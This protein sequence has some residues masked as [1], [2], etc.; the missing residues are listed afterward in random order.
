MRQYKKS[1]AG[2]A[3]LISILLVGVLLSMVFSLSAIF[4]PKIRSA[5]DIKNSVAAAYAAES[6]L[7]WCFYQN[8]VGPVPSPIMSN[9]AIFIIAPTDCSTTPVTA[10]GTYRGINRAFQISF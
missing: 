1:Q 2:V 6:G 7:E 3:I 10:I 4:I 9:N 5:A 8:Q